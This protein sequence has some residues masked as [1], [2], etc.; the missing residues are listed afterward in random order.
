[1]H[2][3]LGMLSK[4][5]TQSKWFTV[6]DKRILKLKITRRIL[7][8]QLKHR[9]TQLYLCHLGCHLCISFNLVSLDMLSSLE[10]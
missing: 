6:T 3:A 1:M 4:L 7:T 9:E 10:V 5:L 2:R 8:E